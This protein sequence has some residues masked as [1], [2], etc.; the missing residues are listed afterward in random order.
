MHAMRWQIRRDGMSVCL[1]EK[2]QV[3]ALNIHMITASPSRAREKKKSALRQCESFAERVLK[4]S[5]PW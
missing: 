5:I 4:K 3:F 2:S 1:E